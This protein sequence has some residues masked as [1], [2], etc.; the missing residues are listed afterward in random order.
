[1]GAATVATVAV[2]VAAVLLRSPDAPSAPE[3]AAPPEPVATP[4]A[5]YDTE[6]VAVAREGFCADVPEEAVEEALGAEV[7]VTRSWDDGDRTLLSPGLRDIAH[8]FGCAWSAD[9]VT[10]RA[11]VFAPPVTQGQAEDLVAEAGSGEGCRPMDGAPGF[12]RPT[13]AVFCG[14]GEKTPQASYRGLFGDAWLTCTLAVR[15]APTG[16]DLRDRTGRW[17]VEVLEAARD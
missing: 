10:A 16:A 12:G 1:M 7:E 4:L 9:G 3:T 11:W 17:C 14:R 2:V 13:T 5:D 15:G 8:E 6:Q